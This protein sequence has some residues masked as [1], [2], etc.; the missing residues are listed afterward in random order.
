MPILASR[1]SLESRPH[2][3][4]NNPPSN[5]WKVSVTD[6]V[7]LCLVVVAVGLRCFTKLRITKS[8]GSEDWVS[9]VALLFFITYAALNFVQ[10]FHYGGGRHSWDLPPEMYNGYLTISAINSYLYILG[11]ALAKVSL[12]LFLYRVFRVDGKFRIAAWTIGIILVVWSVVSFLLCVFSCRPIKASWNVK[13]LLDPKTHCYPKTP[14]VINYHG[15]CNIIT[16]FALLLLPLPMV[17]KLQMNQKKKIGVGVVLATGI[18]ICAI[19]IVRQHI[20]WT[21]DKAGDNWE[22]TKN[23]VWMSLEFSMSIVIACLPALAPLLKHYKML[24]S[25]IPSSIRSKFPSHSGVSKQRQAWSAQKLPGSSSHGDVERGVVHSTE[26]RSHSSWQTPQSWHGIEP[27]KS[28]DGFDRIS[29]GSDVALQ[30]VLPTH[31]ELKHKD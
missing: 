26:H 16:D 6:S 2:N 17:W 18:F 19:S 28:V 5:A 22:V 10:R 30:P 15:F 27:E 20:L 8:P 21:T 24:A 13:L 11:T 25:L 23:K 1:I 31:R 29:E 12:L 9:V 7:G 14:N 4:Y 3:Y